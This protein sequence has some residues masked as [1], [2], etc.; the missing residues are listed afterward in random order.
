M[1]E[2]QTKG[3]EREKERNVLGATKANLRNQLPGKFPGISE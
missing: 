1:C 3:Q 2:G